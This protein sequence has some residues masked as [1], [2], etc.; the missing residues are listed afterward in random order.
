MQRAEEEK[1]RLVAQ[2]P[3]GVELADDATA[4]TT[5]KK[6]TGAL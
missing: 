1:Q 3:E 5:M 4:H 6:V 2:L